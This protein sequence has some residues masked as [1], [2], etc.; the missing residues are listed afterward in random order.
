MQQLTLTLTIDVDGRNAGDVVDDLLIDTDAGELDQAT[1]N[2]VRQHLHR[3]GDFRDWR[4]VRC[5]VTV[6]ETVTV[7]E[8][9]K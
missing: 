1:L 9:V 2:L 3:M 8:G 7:P 5:A 6:P 4:I